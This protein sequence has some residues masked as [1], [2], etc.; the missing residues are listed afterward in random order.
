[1]PAIIWKLCCS[2]VVLLHQKPEGKCFMFW[3]MTGGYEKVSEDGKPAGIVLKDCKRQ[4]AEARAVSPI[5][6]L[7]AAAGLNYPQNRAQVL[8]WKEIV[9]SL[10]KTVQEHAIS[11]VVRVHQ[12]KC[13]KNWGTELFTRLEICMCYRAYTGAFY[14]F[15]ALLECRALE[16][17]V[18]GRTRAPSSSTQIL[19]TGERLCPVTGENG[20]FFLKNYRRNSLRRA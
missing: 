13:N 18:G 17:V 10:C 5:L 4:R 12:E 14:H 1:M 7:R 16:W 3:N 2:S 11:H 9:G 15:L 8:F 19:R 6:L 20:H